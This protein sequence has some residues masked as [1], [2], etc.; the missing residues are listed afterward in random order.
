MTKPHVHV[1]TQPVRGFPAAL[2]RAR[3]LMSRLRVDVGQGRR[4]EI[5]VNPNTTL[6][7]VLAEVCKRRKLE[8]DDHALRHTLAGKSRTLDNGLTIRFAGL[9]GNATLELIS[10]DK[11]VL[12][13]DCTIALQPEG[14]ARQTGKLSTSTTLDKVIAQLAP[15]FGCASTHRASFL[16][17]QNNQLLL[18]S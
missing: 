8:P 18:G 7:F 5:A 4:E 3:L 10:A 16:L 14:G 9:S 1:H 2:R 6:G 13:G 12:H 11:R 15:D 17:P